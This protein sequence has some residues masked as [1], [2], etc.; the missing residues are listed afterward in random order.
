[1]KL[2]IKNLEVRM[3]LGVYEYEKINLTKVIFNLEIQMKTNLSSSKND[4]SN[5]LDYDLLSRKIQAHFEAK[6]FNLIEDVV[7]E[8]AILIKQEKQV[9]NC[10]IR[11]T[12]FATHDFIQSI[13]IEEE[14]Y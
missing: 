11:V 12:K 6:S 5:L 14:F 1:M 4:L 2:I 8:T 9:K 13:S 3:F 7:Y 10:K